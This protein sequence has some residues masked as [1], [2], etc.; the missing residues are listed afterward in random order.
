MMT[1]FHFI[2]RSHIGLAFG[3]IRDSQDAAQSL[4][5]NITYYKLLAFVTSA[6]FAGMAGSFYAHYLLI[7]TPTSVFSIGLMIEIIAMAMVGGTGTFIGPV[8]G[9][10][11]L[12]LGLEYLRFMGEYRFITYGILLVVIILFLPQGLGKKFFYEKKAF[13]IS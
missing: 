7:L 1:L 9:S 6:F 12:T 8:L 5:I 4:G 2:F 11:L 13:G 10:F 3:S